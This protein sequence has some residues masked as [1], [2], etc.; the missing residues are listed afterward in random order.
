MHKDGSSPVASR[1]W[2]VAISVLV[3]LVT[4]VPEVLAALRAGVAVVNITADKPTEPVHDPIMAKALV[5]EDGSH[6]LVIISLDIVELHEPTVNGVRLG[7]QQELGIDPSVVLLNASHNHRTEGQE[8][9]DMVPR[10]VGAVKQASQ[11][12]VAARIGSGVGHEDRITANR[13]LRTKDG[14]HWTIRRATP[15][16]ADADVTAE[17]GPLDTEIGLLRVDTLAGKP[18]ALVYNFAGHAYGGVPGGGV[19]ADFPGFASHV[20]EAAWPGAVALFVQGCAGDITPIR[21]KDFDAPQPTQELGEKLGLSA[22]QAAQGIS[23]NDQAVIRVVREVV[24]LPRRTDTPERI[25]ELLAEQEKILQSFVG[26]GCGSHGAGTSLNLKSFLSLNSK[27]ANSPDF[28]SGT[29]DEYRLE[30]AAVRKDLRQL[31]VENRKRLEV[32]RKNVENMDKLI[33]IRTNLGIM[34]EQ[35]DKLGSGPIPVEIQAVR[36]G[37]FVLVTF[38]GESFAETGLRIEKQSPFPKTFVAGYTNGEIIGDYAPTADCY[39]KQTYEDS[40]TQL[41]PQWEKMYVQ[42]ALELIRRLGQPAE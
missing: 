16:P 10:I 22:L 21:Y 40:Y 11:N 2:G 7:V 17:T 35:L 32:Y 13:R 34:Q 30:D 33:A 18:L 39:D 31:D 41:A 24:P 6:R 28:P 38:P 1:C 12:M 8:A 42:K 9:K 25:K 15:S 20:I 14:K 36:I 27:Y 29:A 19:T 3:L 4:A 23:T 5:L 37:D 26:I